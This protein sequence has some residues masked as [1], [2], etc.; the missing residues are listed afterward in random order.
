MGVEGCNKLLTLDHSVVVDVDLLES[1]LELFLIPVRV[2]L[3]CYVCQD[4][5]FELVFE[6][7][8]YN[9]YIE[10]LQIFV[11]VFGKGDFAAGAVDP[12]GAQCLQCCY[13]FSRVA[14]QHFLDK[15]GCVA[16]YQISCVTVEPTFASL[17]R[18]RPKLDVIEDLSLVG[19]SKGWI[20]K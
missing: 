6:L 8:H 20:S 18:Q 11:D 7:N 2:E 19:A 1:P 10:V 14:L 3:R 16:T 17:E 12:V 15:L 5:S 9:S 13:A 4:D